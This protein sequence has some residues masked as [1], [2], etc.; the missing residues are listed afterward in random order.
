M[1]E[2]ETLEKPLALPNADLYVK[3]FLDIGR[4]RRTIPYF[5]SVILRIILDCGIYLLQLFPCK[6]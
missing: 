3:L 6:L 2:A 4:E 1:R 5:D